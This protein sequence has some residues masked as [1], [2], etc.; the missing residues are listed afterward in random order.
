MS[1]LAGT[2]LAGAIGAIPALVA[3]VQNYL[4]TRKAV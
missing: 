2:A 3:I 4:E 1:Q